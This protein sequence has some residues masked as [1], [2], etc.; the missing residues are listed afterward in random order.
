L[1]DL[2]LISIINFG[3]GEESLAEEV[4]ARSAGASHAVGC[5]ISQLIALCRRAR[6]CVGGDTG[7][8][9]L[10]AALR[11]PVVAIYGPTDPERNGPFGAPMIALRSSTSITD[12]ARRGEPEA[13]ML[14]ITAAQV[15]AAA[16]QLLPQNGRG[17]RDSA[18]N[19]GLER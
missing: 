12:H 19:N 6:L 5:S 18:S 13:G 1:R 11:V 8:T 7:P 9:H 16:S 10:A 3:P 2:G 17:A 4:V 15:I 14:T